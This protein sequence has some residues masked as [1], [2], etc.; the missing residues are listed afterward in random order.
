MAIRVAYLPL[1]VV[2]ICS[3]CG[4]SGRCM[5][6]FLSTFQG[7][8]DG[9]GRVSVPASFRAVLEADGYP[10]VFVHQALDVPA[11]ECGGHRLL[12]QIDALIE[13]FSP[14]SQE[15]D[16]ISTALLGGSEVLKLDPEGR[17]L[18]PERFKTAAGIASEV[19]FVGLGEKFRLWEPKQFSVHLDEAKSRLRDV[20]AAFSRQ[21]D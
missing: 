21:G 14:Y 18:L 19:V 5:G 13:R 20:R 8:L 6:R 16:L 2:R 10:G 15:R 3:V 7:R 11:L 17:M 4:L 12:G 9:K 1:L